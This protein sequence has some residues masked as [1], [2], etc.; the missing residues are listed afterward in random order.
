MSEITFENMLSIQ[1]CV[2]KIF[3]LLHFIWRKV[4]FCIINQANF[5]SSWI[6]SCNKRSDRRLRW[7]CRNSLWFNSTTC[8]WWAKINTLLQRWI[9]FS[10]IQVSSMKIFFF[11][12]TFYRNQNVVLLTKYILLYY[13]HFQ[14]FKCHKQI[15]IYF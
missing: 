9:Q 15:F 1:P 4:V 7:A 2:G 11:V 12:Q 8:S 3:F 5:L 13:T 6:F 10:Y 14:Y